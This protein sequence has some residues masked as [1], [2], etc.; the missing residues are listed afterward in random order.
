MV[1]ITKN[2]VML[3]MAEQRHQ[4]HIKEI[5]DTAT[6]HNYH[7]EY[8]HDKHEQQI[9][10]NSEEEKA[11]IDLAHHIAEGN[12]ERNLAERVEKAH[13]DVEHAKEVAHKTH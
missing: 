3:A 13:N 12:R 6:K 2:K 8:V 10:H 5:K 9:A 4:E 7:A 11:R 1:K